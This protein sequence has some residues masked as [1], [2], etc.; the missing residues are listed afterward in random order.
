MRNKKNPQKR[1]LEL[2]T[3][4]DADL[5]FKQNYLEIKYTV[6][7]Y[8]LLKETYNSKVNLVDNKYFRSLY[9][10]FYAM[11]PLFA[12][13]TFIDN[14]YVE[15]ERIRALVNTND[16]DIMD[17]TK[18]LYIGEKPKLQFSFVSKMMNIENDELYPIYDS[19]VAYLFTFETLSNE[20]D[21]RLIQLKERYDII[22]RT[23]TEILEKEE[24]VR[25][26][27]EFKNIFNCYNTTNMRIMDIIFWQLG[28]HNT[29]I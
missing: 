15:M 19:K 18:K 14:Y 2:V 20:P 13:K 16:L 28:K 25:A 8:E 10:Q 27:G 29:H 12:S 11:S 22:Y 7:V 24:S 21:K 17:L 5:F 9:G 4:N 3:T 26:I 1:F 23:Y 6:F